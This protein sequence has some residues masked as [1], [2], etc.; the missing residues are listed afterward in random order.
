MGKTVVIGVI[1]LRD[2]TKPALDLNDPF[3]SCE[4]WSSV[5]PGNVR[6]SA[7]GAVGALC[8]GSLAF[9]ANA[10]LPLDGSSGDLQFQLGQHLLDGRPDGMVAALGEQVWTGGD[11]VNLDPEGGTGP[12]V[13]F[14]P[15]AGLVNLE[16][17]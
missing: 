7:A 5:E 12:A 4:F 3:R 13:A 14:Q 16:A 9:A 8:C 15:H 11:E 6:R 17:R 10:P 1:K 2:S